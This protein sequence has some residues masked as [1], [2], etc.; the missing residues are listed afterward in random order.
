MLL[1]LM[2]MMRD[3]FD[4]DV[5]GYNKVCHISLLPNFSHWPP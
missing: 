1:L 5:D 2:M 3:D 4:A